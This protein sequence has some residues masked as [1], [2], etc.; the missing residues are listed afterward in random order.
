MRRL[1][2]AAIATALVVAGCSGDSRPD[3]KED[4]KAALLSALEDL[5]KRDGRA[6]TISL[7]ATTESLQALGAE[8][9]GSTRITEEDA[10]KI[11]GS[12]ARLVSRGEGEEAQFELV[13][14]IAGEEDLTVKVVDQVLYLQ[15]DADGLAEAFGGE[16]SQLNALARRA[17]AQGF[18]FVRAAVE[19]DWIAIRG[20]QQLQQQLGGARPDETAEQQ[21]Q[22]IED[23]MQ[24][25]RETAEVTHAGSDDVGDHLAASL[26]VNDFYAR[27]SRGLLGSLG[28]AA[29]FN[30]LPDLGDVP[31]ETV[32]VDVWVED[33]AITQAV[34]DLAQVQRVAGG[35]DENAADRVALLIQLE[36]FDE[37]VEPPEDAVEVEA[38]QLLQLLAG[39][40]MFPE[41]GGETPGANS[42]MRFPGS[43]GSGST[44][45]FDCSQLEG[46]PPAVLKKFTDECPELQNR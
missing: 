37:D 46:A 45:Q 27:V 13:V 16:A 12:S 40:M 8:R 41:A 10:Q 43:S 32:V 35:G 17:E 19:G 22:L 20:A 4:P 1:A 15:A 29:G 9:R 23:I 7:D 6:I 31:E 18:D 11:L 2:A 42:R 26:S 30:P 33:G 14:T 34:F 38:Q 21:E 36:E 5:R 25:I 3:A 44:G 39:M 28:P 24:A